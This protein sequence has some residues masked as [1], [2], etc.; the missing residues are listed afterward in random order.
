VSE[1]S[2][3][4]MIGSSFGLALVYDGW[5]SRPDGRSGWAALIAA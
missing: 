5:F 2:A 4:T 1:V 3:S